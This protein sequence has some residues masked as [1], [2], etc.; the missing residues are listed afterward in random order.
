MAN[1]PATPFQKLAAAFDAAPREEAREGGLVE[2]FPVVR[3]ESQIEVSLS[4]GVAPCLSVRA[5]EEEAAP[6]SGFRKNVL[7][8]VRAR[9][10]YPRLVAR[11]VSSLD[12]V[13]AL[14]ALRSDT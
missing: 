10:V 4:R 5:H 13:N 6:S 1:A 8:R 9:L 11:R 2:V 3:K 14:L 7:L 12:R